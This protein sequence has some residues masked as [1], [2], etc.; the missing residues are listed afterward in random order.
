MA[1][2]ISRE[3]GAE[4]IIITV[5]RTTS[6][7]RFKRGSLVLGTFMEIIWPIRSTWTDEFIWF[8]LAFIPLLNL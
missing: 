6:K 3:K 5:E 8:A 7:G 1:R 4:K 2:A